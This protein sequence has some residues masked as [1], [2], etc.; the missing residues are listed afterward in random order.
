MQAL[1]IEPSLRPR[2]VTDSHPNTSTLGLFD[3]LWRHALL[4]GPRG[5]V[6]RKRLWTIVAKA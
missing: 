1:L 4:Y 5:H 2:A 6:L 3:H